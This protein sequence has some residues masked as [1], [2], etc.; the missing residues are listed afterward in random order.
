[1]MKK[2]RRLFYY[3]KKKE[4][5][6]LTLYPPLQ[7]ARFSFLFGKGTG[8]HFHHKTILLNRKKKE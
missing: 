2:K 6:L 3:G 5:P 7:Y 4:S 8:Y 1:M